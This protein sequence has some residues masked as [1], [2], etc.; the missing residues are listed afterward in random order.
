LSAGACAVSIG[1][2]FAMSAE[3]SVPEVTKKAL[4]EKTSADITRTQQGRSQ[5]AIMFGAQPADD[6][7]NNTPGLIA[8]LRTGTA[9]HIFIGNAITEIQEIL[10]VDTIVKKLM[11]ISVSE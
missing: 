7:E 5:R 10:P 8:G 3:S 1:T 9:G 2:M 4:L 6:D 11:Y